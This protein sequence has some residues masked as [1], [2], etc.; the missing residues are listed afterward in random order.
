MIDGAEREHAWLIV[1]AGGDAMRTKE[2]LWRLVGCET[3][4]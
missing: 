3:P 4:K 2:F 1:L